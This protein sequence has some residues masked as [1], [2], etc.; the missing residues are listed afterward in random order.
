METDS[1][2]FEN[3]EGREALRDVL[4]ENLNAFFRPEFLNRVDE[5][6][7]FRP[8]TKEVLRKIVDIELGGV[9]RL[10]A[11]RRVELAV[12]DAVKDHL[13]NQGYQPALG[14]RPLKRAILREVQ[15]PLAE[16]LLSGDYGE[17]SKVK[18]DLVDEALRFSRIE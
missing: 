17:R 2:L 1:R 3:E 4:L 13:V 9:D 8:L 5:V 11:E 6:V 7:V 14:A 12:S 15:D 10:L 18:V 16:A